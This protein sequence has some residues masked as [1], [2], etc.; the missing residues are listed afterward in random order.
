MERALRRQYKKRSKRESPYTQVG[1]SIRV[2]GQLKIVTPANEI[3][4]GI[5]VWGQYQGRRVERM[6]EERYEGNRRTHPRSQPGYSVCGS[7][8]K[9]K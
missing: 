5:L 7:I 8:W 3:R 1:P 6:Q 9:K 4:D 2:V